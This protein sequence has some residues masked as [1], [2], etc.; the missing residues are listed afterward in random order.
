M[1]SSTVLIALLCFS[2]ADAA[3]FLQRI[4]AT[5]G[6]G[7]SFAQASNMDEKISAI[8][9]SAKQVQQDPQVQQEERGSFATYDLRVV[10]QLIFGV[11][12]YFL[13]VKQYPMLES[14]QP[15]KEAIELQ[16][17]DAV[18]ATLKTSFPNLVLSW[19]CTGPRAAHTFHSTGI[20]DYWPSCVMMT[21]FPCC[22]LWAVNAFTDLNTK[23]GGEKQNPLMAALCACFCS[24]CLVAQDAQSLDL[25]TGMETQ[26]YG[27]EPRKDIAPAQAAKLTG[28]DVAEHTQGKDEIEPLLH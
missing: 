18:S 28:S 22:S 14:L 5:K 17:C 24:C 10:L 11:A 9:A 20:L 27:V 23:L 3:S 4:E 1:V 8:V 19:C 26:L 21:C 12:Y 16:K 7:P 2:G 25:I 6:V 13:I 15:S